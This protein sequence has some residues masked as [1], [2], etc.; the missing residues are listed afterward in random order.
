[1]DASAGIWPAARLFH[2]L[3]PL[4][5]VILPI[6][7][8]PW[9]RSGPP[10]WRLRRGSSLC[11]L[12]GT[13]RQSRPPGYPASD[14]VATTCNPIPS[15]PGLLSLF[16]ELCHVCSIAQLRK[17]YHGK[18]RPS[19][20]LIVGPVWM[21]GDSI[22]ELRDRIWLPGPNLGAPDSL[23]TISAFP[24]S[25]RVLYRLRP[26]LNELSLALFEPRPELFKG[27]RGLFSALFDQLP[28]CR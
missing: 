11:S 24:G 2:I 8:L 3:R 19:L 10:P 9:K 14:R 7:D 28:K 12:P 13:E 15:S 25:S 20:L 6:R 4:P 22:L 27:N 21:S 26:P 17:Y 16:G 23:S 5:A 18:K 1:M